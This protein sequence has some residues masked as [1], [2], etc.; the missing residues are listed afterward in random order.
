MYGTL[1]VAMRMEAT[2]VGRHLGIVEEFA[3]AG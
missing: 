1:A 2:R 3:N